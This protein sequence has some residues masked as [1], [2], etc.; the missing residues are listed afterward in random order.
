MLDKIR[1]FVSSFIC[2]LPYT[3]FKSAPRFSETVA[4]PEVALDQTQAFQ[5]CF[6][7]LMHILYQS[8]VVKDVAMILSDVTPFPQ[9]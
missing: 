5:R 3:Y 9:T 4:L 6:W 1:F 7:Y 8:W 2:R